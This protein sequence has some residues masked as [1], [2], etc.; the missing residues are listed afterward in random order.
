MNMKRS[1]AALLPILCVVVR[2]FAAVGLRAVTPAEADAAFQALN[3]VY[4]DPAAKSFRKEE[5]GDKLADF[6]LEAQLW[7]TVMDQYDRTRSEA[8]K[9]QIDDLY[10]G[11]VARNPD[12]TKNQYNDDIM[13]WA[14]GCTRACTLTGD[15]RYLRKAKAS[16]DFV[17]GTFC[18]TN[19][20]GGIWWSSDRRSKNS[21][22]ESPAVIAAV[23]LSQL[24]KDPAYLEKALALYRWEK[25]TLTDGKGKVFDSIRLMPARNTNSPSGTGTGTN[26]GGSNAGTNRFNGRNRNRG[27][28]STFSLTYNQG[29]YIG[30]S[31]VL[32]RA[33]RDE[34]YLTEARNTA[35]WTRSNLCV[36]A[37]QI[38]KSENQGDGG[39]FKGIFVRYM[40]LFVRDGGGAEF[41]PWMQANADT[42]WRNRRPADNLMGY[43]WSVPAGPGIQSQ[44][45]SSAVSLVLDFAREPGR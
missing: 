15:A 5:T 42:A 14:I 19:L 33:T 28:L 30:A 16:F 26:A 41:L 34:A 20:G 9:R 17:Y 18:D 22:I 29:T 38:L 13:W 23:R 36:G 32:Y 43:D 1:P 31:V 11:F 37:E 10:D 39:A 3:Q 40:K 2:L 4:W 45:A 35:N 25:T 12:W 44:S 21:C 6:W 7:D 27:P 8:V 24:L